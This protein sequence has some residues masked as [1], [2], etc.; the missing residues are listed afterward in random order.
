L[1][2]TFGGGETFTWGVKGVENICGGGKNEGVVKG[3]RGGSL[4]GAVKRGG[5]ELHEQR[6]NN[7]TFNL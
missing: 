7:Q 6:E 4:W 3:V 2:E 5:R 1:S